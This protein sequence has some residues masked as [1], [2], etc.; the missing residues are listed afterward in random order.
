MGRERYWGTP[1]PVWECEDCKHQLCVGAVK[2]L[3]ELTGIDQSSLDLHRPYIDNIQFPC[4]KCDGKMQRVPELIDVWFDSG[5]MPYAQWHYPFENQEQFKS[6]YP[7]D[8]IC[9]AVDQN[10][11]LVLFAACDQHH[12]L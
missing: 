9:E 12:A 7:A 8:Y 11:W 10:S 4:P 6:Q 5:S 2:E 3:T 1:L